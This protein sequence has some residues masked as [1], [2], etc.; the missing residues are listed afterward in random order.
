MPNWCFNTLT[1]HGP[2]EE[3]KRFKDG[4]LRVDDRV[5]L[6]QS[7]LP[8]PQK[9]LEMRASFTDIGYET[10]FNPDPDGY[11][12]VL[13][14]PEIKKHGIE[15]REQLMELVRREYPDSYENGLMINNN[16]FEFGYR[17][18]YWWCIANWGTKWDVS[19]TKF[20]EENPAE[21]IYEFDSAWNPPD[22]GIHQIAA[23]FPELDFYLEYCEPMMEFQGS[24]H[25]V[26]GELVERHFES[27]PEIDEESKDEPTTIED[28]E[29]CIGHVLE[30]WDEI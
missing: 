7:Y 23:L 30:N 15:T 26:N 10:F 20:N 25:W 11:S 8:C 24:D 17:N 14:L 1:I 4:L 3:I 5:C 22:I 13:E 2:A 16:L 12:R 19:Y 28:I 21:L 27:L 29:A 9:L 18:W 6:L